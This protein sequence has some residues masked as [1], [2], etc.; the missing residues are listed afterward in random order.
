M[1]KNF[2]KS[3]RASKSRQWFNSY[4]NFTEAVDLAYWWSFSGR[5]SAL[6]PAQQACFKNVSLLL[7]IHMGKITHPGAKN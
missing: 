2:L 7:E 6:Q 5:G 1:T 3:Q 4:G